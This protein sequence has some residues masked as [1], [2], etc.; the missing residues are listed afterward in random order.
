MKIICLECNRELGEKAPFDDHRSTHT[1]C[2]Q[3]IEKRLKLTRKGGLR[4][5]IVRQSGHG[6]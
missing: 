4:R 5:K 1:I 6:G 3:C 2:P